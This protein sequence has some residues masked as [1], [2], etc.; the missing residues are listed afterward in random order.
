[1]RLTSGQHHELTRTQFQN[2]QRWLGM[3]Q[4]EM[5]N[6]V[7]TDPKEGQLDYSHCLSMTLISFERKP[8]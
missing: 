8:L 6:A 2:Q 7:L 3:F 5:K 1:M 4:M